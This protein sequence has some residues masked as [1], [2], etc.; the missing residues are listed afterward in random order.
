MNVTTMEVL[1][2]SVHVWVF[3]MNPNFK[4][5]D[6]IADLSRFLIEFLNT[7]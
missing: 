4:T 3:L 6:G 7:H 2:I 1:K 5:K